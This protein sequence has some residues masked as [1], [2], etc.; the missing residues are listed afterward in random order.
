MK[1]KVLIGFVLMISLLMITGCGNKTNEN[2]KA[3]KREKPTADGVEKTIVKLN[4]FIP[5]GYTDNTYNGMMGVYDFY[6]GDVTG[7]DLNVGVVVTYSKN[8]TDNDMS[9]KQYI[10]L[11]SNVAQSI[12]LSKVKKE[13]INEIDWFT[14]SN[15]N[16]YYYA[17][18]YED[19]LYEVTVKK[20]ND[21]KELFTKTNDMVKK[22]LFFLETD[23][24]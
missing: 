1:K 21:S 10:E 4:L 5:E 6:T 19:N 9:A 17:A 18:E 7:S 13:T 12:H 3:K 24:E 14:F 22:T 11:K 16:A 8:Y 15:E 23:E 2:E 20:K